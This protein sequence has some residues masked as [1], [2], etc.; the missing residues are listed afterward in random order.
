MKRMA[1]LNILG[2]ICMSYV[3]AL[4][5]LCIIGCSDSN[6]GPSSSPE[7]IVCDKFNLKVTLDGQLLKVSVDTDLQDNTKLMV[8]VSRTYYVKGTVY[9]VNYFSERSTVGEWRTQKSIPLDNY[10]WLFDLRKVQ[11]KM[12]ALVGR[13]DVEKISDTIE[14]SMVVPINQLDPRFGWRNENLVGKAVKVTDLRIVEDEVQIRYPLK[15]SP[16]HRSSYDSKLEL[17]RE[18]LPSELMDKLKDK[19]I[20]GNYRIIERNAYKT[21]WL[22]Y[23]TKEYKEN[24]DGYILYPPTYCYYYT[25]NLNKKWDYEVFD[26]PEETIYVKELTVVILK[27]DGKEIR[28]LTP[29]AITFAE[30]VQHIERVSSITKTKRL[31][32]ETALILGRRVATIL[33]ETVVLKPLWYYKRGSL[34]CINGA[35]KESTA[36]IPFTYEVDA[37]TAFKL[38]E[39]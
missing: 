35:A 2:N 10:K 31:E 6:D 23:D 19:P 29:K 5:L 7:K 16:T 18:A 24:K 27:K 38:L 36:D 30:A 8:G 14:I 21:H 1:I 28:K 32:D 37:M 20:K 15:K 4:A 33:G 39:D 9:L 12:V 26:K 13:F 25:P 11:K 34:Y 3:I 17:K 22:V